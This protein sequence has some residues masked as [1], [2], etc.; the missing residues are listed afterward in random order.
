M[1]QHLQ[2]VAAQLMENETTLYEQSQYHYHLSL[3]NICGF[4]FFTVRSSKKKVD[5]EWLKTVMASGTISDKLSA[6]TLMIQVMFDIMTKGKL[7]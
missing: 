5:A 4:F 1:I 3:I 2:S 7:T 6:R